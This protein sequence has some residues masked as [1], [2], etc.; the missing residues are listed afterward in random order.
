MLVHER[1]DL[2]LQGLAI[3]G[4]GTRA[5]LF[6]WDQRAPGVAL[7]DEPVT[8]DTPRAE[9]VGVIAQGLFQGHGFHVRHLIGEV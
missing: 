5:A 9:I 8:V 4:A 3:G 6:Q 1:G 7:L 2:A